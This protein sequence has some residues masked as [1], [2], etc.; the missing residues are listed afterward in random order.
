MRTLNL[1]PLFRSSVGFD[2][3]A[4]ML[5]SASRVEQGGFPPYN[6]ELIDEDTYKISMAVAGFNQSEIEITAEQNTL[7]VAGRQSAD[8]ERNYLH[9]GIAT[10]NFERKFQ[11]ADHVKVTGA[12]MENGL[13]HIEL[14]REIP[15][16][17][18]PR[19]IEISGEENLLEG[20]K[21]QAA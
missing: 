10:R 20:E 4:N 14:R 5:D 18:K 1:D 9:Q 15:E 21:E 3:L 7:T 2:H 16:A 12:S 6:I 11:L 13:L 19:R 8:K 17:M